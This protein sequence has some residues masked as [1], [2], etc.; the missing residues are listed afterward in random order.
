MAEL[1]GAAPRL[2]ASLASQINPDKIQ[3]VYLVGT[4]ITHLRDQLLQD[5]Y[6]AAA[7]H[8]YPADQL[9]QLSAD[10]NTVLTADD[11]VLLK[12]SHGIHLEKVLA[13]IKKQ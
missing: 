8:Y 5:G 2:H 4:A 7:I 6:P 3:A 11:M 9:D 1:G 12:A 13:A 10:L